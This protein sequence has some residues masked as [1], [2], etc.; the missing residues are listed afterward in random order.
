MTI[1]ELLNDVEKL[2]SV[3]PEF[4]REYVWTREQAK[5]LLV[6]LFREYPTGALLMWKT[7]NPPDIKNAT[8]PKDRIGMTNVI[9]DGQQR[10]TT[11]YL[12]TRGEV[13]PYYE[14]DE[15]L[16]DPRKLYFNLDDGE[17][18][19]YQPQRME[20]T[21]T[22]VPVVD[23]FT[24]K[25]AIQVFPIAQKRAS[26]ETEAFAL[27]QRFM[28]NLTRLRNVLERSY[29]VQV[30]PPSADVDDA[31]DVFD[32]VNSLGT[33]LTDA[34]LALAHITGKWPH[35]RREMKLKID[36]LGE[37]RFWFDLNFMTRALT[38]V[39]HTRALFE[40]IHAT[41]REDLLL[42]WE[43][44]TK[45]L[46]YM[47]TI[48]PG[49]AAIHST[50][51]LNTN[52]VLAPVV[53]YLAQTGGRFDNVEELRRCIRWL[54]AASAWSRYSSQT[55]QR[56]DHDFG[57][58]GRNPDPWPELVEGIID[59]RGRIEVKE[60][61]LE[62]RGIQHPLY[63]M[64]HVA[65]KRNAAED[66]FNGALLAE[67]V[68]RAYQL[69]SHHIFPV[70]LLYS[71]VG[72]YDPDNHLHRKLVNEI[73][74][75]AFLTG[76]TN[77][78]L[79]NTQPAEYLGEVERRFPG[80]L[81]KQFV[82]TDPELWRV[83]RYEDFLEVRRQ[84][85]AKAIDELMH[86]LPVEVDRA[87]R[88]GLRELIAAGESQVVEFKSS[89]RWDVRRNQVNTELQKVIAKAVAGFLNSQGGTLVIGVADDGVILGLAADLR[90][91]GRSDLDGYQ[92]QLVQVLEKYLTA[93]FLQH[94]RVRF[95]RVDELVG[96]IV[97]VE[98]SPQPVFLH[99]GNRREFY[100]RIGNTTRSFDLQGAHEYITMRWQG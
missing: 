36:A 83:D 63:R 32:R 86:D 98:P 8:V 90:S 74:N 100:A 19:Y 79:S 88:P 3:L 20:G 65:A 62:G 91:L 69:H 44:L 54:Y 77:L 6:S 47:V 14:E 42:G 23:C 34:E 82:P 76:D 56:L 33:K 18:Q 58:I 26:D 70:S 75:R 52:N 60:G 73:A 22:W 37:K 46:D 68:G 31:I 53:V 30:V 5:Q 71:D 92:Q 95:D 38:G 43:K 21:P 12:L 16:N 66:W 72:G 96:C 89:L 35:A 1:R 84:L 50:E 29:P 40:T 49:H 94:V 85:L 10:L 99:D 55:D 59:Q 57:I 45:I 25:E 51:D 64:A 87:P 80:A 15:I 67:P 27:A 41:P 39:V 48:L 11:L 78:A 24:S 4:Q 61:D 97:D 17:F 9:L 28:D 7:D 13:P 93:A 81:A 2:N